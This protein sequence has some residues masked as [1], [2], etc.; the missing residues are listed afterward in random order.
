MSLNDKRKIYFFALLHIVIWTALPTILHPNMPLDMSELVAW[1]NEW[2]WGYHKHPPLSSWITEIAMVLSNKSMLAYFLLSQLS[3][4]ITLILVWKLGK[5]FLDG[6][7]AFMAAIILEGVYYYNFT[8]P[9]FNPN[10]LMIPLWAG[11]ILAMWYALQTSKLRYWVLVG[12]ISALAMLAKYYSVTLLLSFLLMLVFVKDCRVHW[13]T[14][15]PY[16]AFGVFLLCLLPHLLWMYQTNFSTI[17]YAFE[18]S[19]S[20]YRIYN[21][22]L[23]PLKFFF[24]QLIAVLAALIVFGLAYKLE[25]A[26]KKLAMQKNDDAFKTKFLLFCGLMPFFIT[27]AI[28][29]ILS[30]KLLSMWGTPLWSLVGIML[31]YFLSPDQLSDR[32]QRLFY[33]GIAV[34]MLISVSSYVTSM[35]LGHHKRA[36]FNGQLAGE[37]IAKKW[38]EYF[39]TL[40][41]SVVVGD[42]WLAGNVGFYSGN[43]ASAFTDMDRQKAPWMTMD[44]LNEKGGVIIWNAKTEGESVPSRF[45]VPGARI[46]QQR[47]LS[48]PWL[49]N[50]G[51]EPYRLGWAILEPSMEMSGLQ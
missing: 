5:E 4:G 20:D 41:F 17:Y 51:K 11:A 49:N 39:P 8:S 13:K 6:S 28:S 14:K 43:D 12:F 32:F 38:K 2:Q 30:V 15:G 9:E 16:V 29:L 45:V 18:R 27:L 37:Y 33:R 50:S 21:H 36:H 22:F 31:F 7:K 10:V 47:S 25:G 1:G 3:I 23:F 42:F 24:V 40:P 26:E 46:V 34:V 19:A 44:I 35:T 48:L